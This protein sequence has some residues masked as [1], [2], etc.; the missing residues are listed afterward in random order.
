MS[1]EEFIEKLL[2]SNDAYRNGDFIV[3][4]KFE[5]RLKN[6]LVE[7]NY[8]VCNP[9]VYDLLRGSK[10]SIKSAVDK[11][12]YCISQITEFIDENEYDYSELS[13][14]NQKTKVKIGCKKH[15]WFWQVPYAHKKGHGCSKC[16]NENST[17]PLK[18]L[19][20]RLEADNWDHSQKVI[21]Y[22]YKGIKSQLKITCK[23]G[24]F[25]S[26]RYDHRVH[27]RNS[28]PHCHKLFLYVSNN[29][30]ITD[31]IS[32]I[33]YVFKLKGINEEFYKVGITKNIKNRIRDIEGKSQYKVE[34]VEY[35]N[36]PIKEAYDKEQYYLDYFKEEKMFVEEEF[37]G[38][39]ECLKQNPMEMERIM[40][41]NE[42]YYS[43]QMEEPDFSYKLLMGK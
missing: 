13:Y 32:V 30:E 16:A 17:I 10:P 27:S 36:L 18:E 15:G 9:G 42:E 2:K 24:H 34:V 37:G 20:E 19:Q 28:C 31:S 23:E 41:Y 5:P 35:K 11:N 22:D 26:T 12:S 43:N 39:T 4:G 7:D 1:H 40:H 25:Y 21:I 33:L 3:L 8:G 6:I 29:I 14:V 38:H